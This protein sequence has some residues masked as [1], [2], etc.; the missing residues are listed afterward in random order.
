MA[1]NIVILILICF[2]VVLGAFLYIEEVEAPVIDNA[3]ESEWLLAASFMCLDGTNF[4]AEFPSSESVDIYV[5][6]S[7]VR[8]LPLVEGDGQRYEDQS[9]AFVFAGEEA[10]VLSK[11]DNVTTTCSQPL[12]ANN[13]PV[14]FGDTGEGSGEV[15]DLV[16][17]VNES[18]VGTWVSNEDRQF[19]REFKEGGIVED[20]HDS[21]HVSRGEW[22]VFTKSAPLAVSFP[23]EDNVV[24]VQ[25]VMEGAESDTLNFKVV[26]LTPDRLEM[27]YLDRGGTLTFTRAQ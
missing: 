10:T 9:Y 19:S 7:L 20:V 18:I 13:A 2:V 14:N 6:G 1:K 27:I 12:D 5:D 11:E 22:V 17:T 24:Y 23:L 21:T 16:A 8:T 15:Q 26:T 4:I 25:L 3:S